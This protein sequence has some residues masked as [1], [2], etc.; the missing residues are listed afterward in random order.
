MN[1]IVKT[2]IDLVKIDSESY[3][4]KEFCNYLTEIFNNL[5]MEVYVDKKSMEK[6]HSD[7]PNLIVKMKAVNS[8]K[9]PVGFSCHMDTVKPGKN[10]EP[11][12]END[13]IKS[14]GNTILASDDKSGIAAIIEACKKIQTENKGNREA[15]FVF[16]TCEEVGLLG[17]KHF[18]YSL[19]QG[20]KNLI[21]LDSGGSFGQIITKAPSQNSI[22]FTVKG[23]K[24]HAGVE[25]EKGI[26]AI[27]AASCGI[28]KMKLGRL[29]SETTCNIG[30]INGGTATNIV[31]DIVKIEGEARS[32]SDEKLEKVTKDMISAMEEA[33]RENNTEL[34]TVCINEYKAY[35]LSENS[36]FIQE[37]KHAVEKVGS[38]PKIASTGGGSDTNIHNANGLNAVNMSTGMMNPHT[39]DEFIKIE[40]L[41]KTSDFIY[42]MLKA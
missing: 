40:D 37:I 34:E 41:I 29:D 24:A 27:Y 25:P 17:A 35:N 30:L 4:E 12:I 9:T 5:D 10:I 32:L 15:W 18:D 26:N 14:S 11:V 16:T 39:S 23:K 20:L 8:D 7:S 6:T 36:P 22:K 21:V 1:N 38:Q 28:S 2:F 33:C 19:I 13:L 31:P 42:E 3:N